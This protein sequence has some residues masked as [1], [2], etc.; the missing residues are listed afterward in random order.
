MLLTGFHWH[1]VYHGDVAVLDENIHY[2]CTNAAAVFVERA[3]EDV[4]LLC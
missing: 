1:G 3:G 2:K 4:C